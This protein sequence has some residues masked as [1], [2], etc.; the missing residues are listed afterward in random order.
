M[1]FSTSFWYVKSSPCANVFQTFI[2]EDFVKV[3]SRTA[4]SGTFRYLILCLLP[5]SKELI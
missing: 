1:T 5:A 2:R 4:V 3:V